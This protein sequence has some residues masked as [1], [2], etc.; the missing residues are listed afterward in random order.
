M[1]DYKIESM[2]MIL[3]RYYI[4]QVAAPLFL[5][6]TDTFSPKLFVT[7]MEVQFILYNNLLV[8][9]SLLWG[10]QRLLERLVDPVLG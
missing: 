1:A 7:A 9:S 5:N 6:T 4:W 3:N 8:S 10:Q 2:F